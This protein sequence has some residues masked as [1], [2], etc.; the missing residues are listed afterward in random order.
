MF[1]TD[2]DGKGRRKDLTSAMARLFAASRIKVET[3]GRPSR[4]FTR[5]VRCG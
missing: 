2:P 1:A 5:M 3:Y 4:Q